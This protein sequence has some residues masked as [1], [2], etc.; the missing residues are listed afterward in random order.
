V[1]SRPP[2]LFPTYLLGNPNLLRHNESNKDRPRRTV[3]FASTP[4]TLAKVVAGRVCKRR[5]HTVLKVLE[6]SRVV[7]VVVTTATLVALLDHDLLR[8]GDEVA[9]LILPGANVRD[10]RR[11]ARLQII[12]RRDAEAED[13]ALDAGVHAGRPGLTGFDAV[14][15][16][17]GAFARRA[18]VDRTRSVF[19]GV[20]AFLLGHDHVVCPAFDAA[21]VVVLRVGS[22]VGAFVAVVCP[23]AVGV[24]LAVFESFGQPVACGFVDR[25]GQRAQGQCHGQQSGRLK[26]V[27]DAGERW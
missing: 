12:A 24:V 11:V 7:S 19:V 21:G 26:D 1:Y 9:L 10:R 8:S 15:D 25:C 5:R 14:G 27:H 2:S 18:A 16:L 23:A 17:E 20:L 3:R 22:D 6:P 13:L 4:E